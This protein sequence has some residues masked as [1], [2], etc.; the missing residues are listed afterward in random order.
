M[1]QFFLTVAALASISLVSCKNEKTTENDAPKEDKSFNV[2]MNAVVQ[3][4]DNFQI[5]YNEDGSDNYPA[6]KYVDVAVKG[7]PVSQEITFK[8]PEDALP[9]SLR[10]DMGSNKEQGEVKILDFKMKY[11]DKQFE[12]KD[13]LFIYYFGNNNQIEYIRDKA[14][15]KPKPIPNEIYD[16]I[17]T[18]TESLKAEIKKMVQ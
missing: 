10:F 8:L 6:D 3:K 1:K 9:S 18:A 13:T 4:D 16:P 14:I 2:I 5:Y 15:A 12:A 11:L 17:F 7:N